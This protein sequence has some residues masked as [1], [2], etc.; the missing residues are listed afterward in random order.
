MEKREGKSR[1]FWIKRT[2]SGA[3]FDEPQF[4]EPYRR[5]NFLKESDLLLEVEYDY[6]LIHSIDARAN[7]GMRKGNGTFVRLKGGS[8]GSSEHH[9]SFA[10]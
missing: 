2:D 8:H 4:A 6:A 7:S 5:G 1:R 3:T 10:V 9:R